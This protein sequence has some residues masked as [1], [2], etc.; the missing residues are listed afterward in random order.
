MIC[1]IL[2]LAA[3]DVTG[4]WAFEVDTQAGAGTP[5]LTFKQDGEKLTGLYKGQLGE[6]P[7]TGA[8]KGNDITFTFTVNAQGVDI[9]FTYTG[10]VSDND[11]KGTLEANAGGQV[12]T[13]TW[14]GKRPPR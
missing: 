1:L 5:T 4:S 11:M 12:F 14:R 13:G 3:L 10:T 2:L 6:A 7:L 8:L 9:T